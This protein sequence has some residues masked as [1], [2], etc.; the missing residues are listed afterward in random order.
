MVEIYTG[1]I[2]N[3][4]KRKLKEFT[5]GVGLSAIILI[6]M[7]YGCPLYELFGIVCPSCGVTRAWLAFF[8]GDFILAV[9]YHALFPVIPI[10]GGLY[11]Y[12]CI[13]PNVCPKWILVSLYVLA[14]LLFVYAVMRWCGFVVMP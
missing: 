5:K 9:R 8:C 12:R 13:F 4:E 3:K 10:L 2:N 11:V 6:L 1:I 7:M 14:I